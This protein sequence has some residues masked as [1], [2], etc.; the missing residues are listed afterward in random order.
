MTAYER[1][2]TLIDRLNGRL[3][4]ETLYETRARATLRDL[5]ENEGK[6]KEIE[7]AEQNLREAKEAA[8]RSESALDKAWGENQDLSEKI[9]KLK[10]AARTKARRRYDEDQEAGVRL[11]KSLNTLDSYIQKIFF[12]FRPFEERCR[13]LGSGSQDPFKAEDY[14]AVYLNLVRAYKCEDQLSV[15]GYIVS[16]MRKQMQDGNLAKFRT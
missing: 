12:D 3:E 9:G 13:D 11:R 7:Q 4:E 2:E 10:E 1:K 14:H 8:M 16:V 6:K 15:V 5:E